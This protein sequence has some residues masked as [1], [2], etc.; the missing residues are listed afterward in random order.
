MTTTTAAAI[1]SRIITCVRELVPVTDPRLRFRPFLNERIADVRTYCL[2]NPQGCT[3]LFQVRDTG[4]TRRPEVSNLDVEDRTVRFEIV[5]AY[6]QDHGWG[7]L[8]ALD[9]DRVMAQDELAIERVIGRGARANF[10]PPT[11]PD[12]TWRAGETPARDVRNGV[13]FL[14]FRLTMGFK[15]SLS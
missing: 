10:A 9:R 6:A 11:Y 4:Q 3:R 13:D 8:G 12:A 14:V 15:L 7:T 2:Q 1:T 5:V